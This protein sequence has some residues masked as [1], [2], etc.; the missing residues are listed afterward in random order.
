MGS[1]TLTNIN[2][3]F[4]FTL[5]FVVYWTYNMD[6]SFSSNKLIFKTNVGDM[7]IQCCGAKLKFESF[8]LLI[9]F[10]RLLISLLFS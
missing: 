6:L 3:T 7:L 2:K 10:S 4:V 5:S 1:K 8:V 9:K